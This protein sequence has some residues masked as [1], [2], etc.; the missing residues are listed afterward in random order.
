LEKKH[1]VCFHKL[2][3]QKTFK[4]KQLTWLVIWWIISINSFRVED[5]I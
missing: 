2:K 4:L 3:C 5:S 1:I